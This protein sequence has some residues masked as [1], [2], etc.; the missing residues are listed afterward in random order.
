MKSPEKVSKTP[1]PLHILFR[2]I[3]PSIGVAGLAI[4]AAMNLV[5]LLVFKKVS[6]EFFSPAWWS[7]WFTCYIV[8][9]TFVIIGVAGI[10]VKRD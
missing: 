5:A 4:T 3:F 9:V 8:W 1:F 7:S 2:R 6:A 10:F